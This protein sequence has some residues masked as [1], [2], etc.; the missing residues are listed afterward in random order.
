MK[1]VKTNTKE[2][3]KVIENLEPIQP[4]KQV[5]V[6]FLF[7]E[8]NLIK[9]NSIYTFED[10]NELLSTLTKLNNSKK[11]SSPN[12]CL[13]Y[14]KTKFELHFN[15]ECEDTFYTGKF[16]SGRFDIGDGFA[17]D[18]K[19]YIYKSVNN[20]RSYM[21]LT[22]KQKENFFKTLDINPNNYKKTKNKDIDYSL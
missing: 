5:Y 6:K 8:N 7:S 15:K 19:E 16:Y 13:A 12:K 14:E 9:D 10:A 11:L 4:K 1:E 22:E 3:T 2:D 18:L 17:S 21:Q 20:P